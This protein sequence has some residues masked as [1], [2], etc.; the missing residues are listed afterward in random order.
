M[1]QRSLLASVAIAVVL[2]GALGATTARRADADICFGPGNQREGFA[3]NSVCFADRDVELLYLPVACP[4]PPASIKFEPASLLSVYCG[5]QS[6]LSIVVTDAKNV[7][8]ANDTVVTFSTDGGGVTASAATTGG[9]A[10]ATF[11][12][13][14]KT[15]GVARVVAS[16]GNLR[17]ERE[18]H[19]G[20][21][22]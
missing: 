16:V 5:S 2:G 11:T 21:V 9:L 1:I 8:V 3:C 22:S 6:T 17:A 14:P 15:S 18:V 19:V 7:A 4:G 13:H 10:Q 20:C 12:V